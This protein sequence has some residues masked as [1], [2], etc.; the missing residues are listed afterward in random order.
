MMMS[1]AMP[2]GPQRRR[3]VNS[4]R[5]VLER[6]SLDELDRHSKP[7]RS[8]RLFPVGSHQSESVHHRGLHN[9]CVPPM[10]PMADTDG[11]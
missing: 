8:S 7:A 9:E 1:R 2:R 11:A 5:C 10:L 3:G 6:V 4:A